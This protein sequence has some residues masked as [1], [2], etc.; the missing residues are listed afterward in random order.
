MPS[1]AL[2]ET[3]ALPG[4]VF[5]KASVEKSLV[6]VE[7]VPQGSTE[8]MGNTDKRPGDMGGWVFGNGRHSGL[9]LYGR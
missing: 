7:R 3:A 2:V 9:W 8:R 6:S 5:Y 1:H 4:T